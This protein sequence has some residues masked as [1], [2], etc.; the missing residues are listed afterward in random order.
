M[1]P[2]TKKIIAREGLILLGL[3]LVGV[4]LHLCLPIIIPPFVFPKVPYSCT[5]LPNKS[6]SNKAL[7]ELSILGNKYELEYDS[8]NPTEEELSE[9]ATSIAIREK[10]IQPTLKWR[11]HCFFADTINITFL[12]IF[13]VSYSFY[14]LVRFI[15]WAIKTLVG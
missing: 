3:L 11:M 12:I 1:K 13:L 9:V 4:I 7:Y 2:L 14:L 10:L 15:R 5:S 6:N 8:Y